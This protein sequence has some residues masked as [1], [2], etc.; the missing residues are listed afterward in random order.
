ML[1]TY[2]NAIEAT[3]RAAYAVALAVVNELGF[4]VI[5]RAG[6]TSGSD[7]VMIRKGEPSND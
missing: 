5:G 3:E 2:S 7:W 6:Q 4:I 1:E